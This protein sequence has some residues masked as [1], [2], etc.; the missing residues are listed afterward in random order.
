VSSI[1]RL[2]LIYFEVLIR[3]EGGVSMSYGNYGGPPWGTIAAKKKLQEAEDAFTDWRTRLVEI[4]E[5]LMRE[6]ERGNVSEEAKSE[7]R[8]FIEEA[9][10]YRHLW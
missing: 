10:R 5:R 3:D 7:F 2:G 9:K 6:M 1:I 4:G 8:K